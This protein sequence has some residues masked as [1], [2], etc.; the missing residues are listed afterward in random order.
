[1]QKLSGTSSSKNK[2]VV[3]FVTT[4]PTKLGLHFFDVSTSFYAF[5]KNRLK[6]F[7]I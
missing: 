3:G 2:N 4:N 7:T 5:Y 1:M 6:G